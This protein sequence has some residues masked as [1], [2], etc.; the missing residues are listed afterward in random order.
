MTK[1]NLELL[2]DNMLSTDLKYENG[3]TYHIIDLNHLSTE[4]MDLN[5]HYVV[6]IRI[7]LDEVKIYDFAITMNTGEIV[8][9]IF[10]L[11]VEDIK[12]AIERYQ[13]IEVDEEIEI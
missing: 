13:I 11:I 3:L 6:H 8:L 10:K 12:I 7:G 4:Y 5:N 9:N 1:Q 2:L